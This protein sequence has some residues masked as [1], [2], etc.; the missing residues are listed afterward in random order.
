MHPHHTPTHSS[1]K[2]LAIVARV[3]T[4]DQEEYGT[5]LDDQEAKGKLLAQLRD[6]SVD[7]RSYTEGGHIYKGDESGSLPLAQRAIMRRLIADAR[8]RR[9]DAVCFTKIDRIARRLKYILEIWD[10]LDDAG[11]T[12]LVID[13]AIDT[14]TPIGRLIRNVLGSIAEFEHDTIVERTSGARR[15]E[16]EAGAIYAPRGKYGYEYVRRDRARG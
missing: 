14:S 16:I 6:Y 4:E 10:A 2:R 12:V 7:D 5:S 1:R 3:S 13:P 15:R 9:F 8:A 11:V